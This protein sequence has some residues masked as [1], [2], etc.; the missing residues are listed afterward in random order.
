MQKWR[1]EAYIDVVNLILGAWLF[2]SPWIFGFAGGMAGW[3][4]WIFGAAI[5]LVAVA[6]MMA[7]AEWEEWLNLIMGL[8]VLVAPWTVGFA[9]E[10]TATR[11]HVVIGVIVAV[12]AALE[13]WLVHRNPPHV[14]A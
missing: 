11:V 4:A 13:L 7:F 2:M 8:W 14:A 5:M 3:N 1:N 12:L 10:A 6:A 9:A